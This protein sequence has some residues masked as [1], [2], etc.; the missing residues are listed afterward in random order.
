LK[1][2]IITGNRTP[3]R[4]LTFAMEQ[5]G[6]EVAFAADPYLGLILVD[7]TGP[8][9]VI[10]DAAVAG[11]LRF[12]AHIR[13]LVLIPVILMGSDPPSKAWE[14]SVDEG[15]DAYVSVFTD[16]AAVV[17]T[18]GSILRRYQKTRGQAASL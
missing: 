11:S 13:K 5:Q 10:L 15:A 3:F 8:D 14:Q 16:P 17:A 7:E 4:R 6:Y 12:C 18:V 2:S 9:M 1:V